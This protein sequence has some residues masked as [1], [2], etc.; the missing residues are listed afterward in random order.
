MYLGIP[1]PS[2]YLLL[3]LIT[4][5]ITVVIIL[6]FLAVGWWRRYRDP[7]NER[8]SSYAKRLAGRFKGRRAKTRGQISRKSEPGR[9]RK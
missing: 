3:L 9:M 6:V 2:Q 5:G 8:D 7:F 1:Q 4:A